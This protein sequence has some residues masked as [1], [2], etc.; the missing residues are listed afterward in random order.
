MQDRSEQEASM[1]RGRRASVVTEVSVSEAERLSTRVVANYN[2]M[3]AL[4]VLYFEVV[5][6]YRLLTEV[7]QVEF[8]FTCRSGRWILRIATWWSAI[9]ACWRRR[10]MARR[11]MHCLAYPA[12]SKPA[13]AA[14]GL[15]RM[16]LSGLTAAN[17]PEQGNAAL[18]DAGLRSALGKARP[19]H[20]RPNSRSASAEA[21]LVEVRASGWHNPAGQPM[22]PV[23]GMLNRSS[24][25][26]SSRSDSRPGLSPVTN[27]I[28]WPQAGPIRPTRWTSR[29]A[30]CVSMS[31]A[32]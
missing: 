25:L 31:S 19:G 30:G 29:A 26:G 3:H 4:S 14:V 18:D 22:G 17:R 16:I 5:Q 32:R 11:A 21:A 27:D 10:S 24:T 9:A 8:C 15:S 13:E 1:A 2:H 28:R 6:I 20:H 12:A 23:L 7:T